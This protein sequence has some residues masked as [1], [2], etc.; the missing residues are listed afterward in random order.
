MRSIAQDIHNAKLVLH[1]W[2]ARGNKRRG[3][4]KRKNR[5]RRKLQKISGNVHMASNANAAGGNG[6][7]RLKAVKTPRN[8]PSASLASHHLVNVSDEDGNLKNTLHKIQRTR[9]RLRTR[10]QR[11]Q[12]KSRV[13]IVVRLI[14]SGIKAKRRVAVG[15][16]KIHRFGKTSVNL[17]LPKDILKDAALRADHIFRLQVSCKR[18]GRHIH[19][20][21]VLTAT[22]ST[23]D[24]GDQSKMWIN[25]YRPYIFI[26]YGVS[27]SGSKVRRK[28]QLSTNGLPNEMPVFTH[29][30]GESTVD[31]CISHRVWVTFEE[32]GLRDLIIYPDGF[33]TD[34]C[35]GA[36]LGKG[37]LT[38]STP[39]TGKF[40][41]YLSSQ[42]VS[43]SPLLKVQKSKAREEQSDISTPQ[44]TAMPQPGKQFQE[45]Q[46]SAQREERLAKNDTALQCVPLYNRPLKL[47]YIQPVSKEIIFT[48]IQDLIQKSCGC[49]YKERK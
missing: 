45:A 12:R 36:C 41:Q 3:K 40:S 6:T 10:K 13:K 2:D 26:Q 15:R 32:L 34:V 4:G 18:C 37:A 35:R 9:S 43:S 5:Y 1:L 33:Y 38:T 19:L 22:P 8:F 28:R 7:Q 27:S 29:S 46:S 44:G 16:V 39:F 23:K 30:S 47:V 11:R 24:N 42:N 17:K 25:P 49:I 14:L 20:D 31:S 48:E 21:R